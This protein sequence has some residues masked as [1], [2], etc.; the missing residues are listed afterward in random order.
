MNLLLMNLSHYWKR[1]ILILSQLLFMCM[2][3]PMF[4][5]SQKSNFWLCSLCVMALIG[6][7]VYGYQME[8]LIKPFSFTLPGHRHIF[9][10]LI[11][12]VIAFW[13]LIVAILI[14]LFWPQNL[15]HRVYGC[16]LTM[17]G[18]SLAFW[19]GTL[20]TDKTRQPQAM[21]GMMMPVIVFVPM[22]VDSAIVEKVLFN[23]L[24]IAIIAVLGGIVTFR[25][26]RSLGQ[27]SLFA[28]YC[29]LQ[30]V[31]MFSGSNQNNL[32]KLR[33]QQFAISLGSGAE[34]FLSGVETFFLKRIEHTRHQGIASFVYGAIYQALGP[35]LNCQL[36]SKGWSVLWIFL[37]FLLS[38]YYGQMG[39][40]IIWLIS[41][42]PLFWAD[43]QIHSTLLLNRGRA[44]RYIV[45]ISWLVFTTI[46]TLGIVFVFLGLTRIAEPYM[47]AIHLRSLDAVFH[48]PD[49]RM[50]Y[51]FLAGAPS[52]ALLRLLFWGKTSMYIASL[53][54]IIN[55]SIGFSLIVTKEHLKQINGYLIA[56]VAI[57]AWALFAAYLYRVCFKKSLAV[58]K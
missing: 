53:M 22:I 36:R 34:D 19:L 15:L 57:A 4:V 38:G 21:I 50:W 30:S 44:Q 10:R 45:A 32:Q 37:L 27:L 6:G 31:G 49:W 47:P 52:I 5:A 13:L 11:F 58:L 35:T 1:P 54:L 24:V 46:T 48:A 56:L 29:G 42:V 25:M 40:C 18:G 23:P 3:L 39:D 2:T 43:F 14:L 12:T 33:R 41:L 7:I 17:A 26:W 9:R 55:F 8:I 28:S 51:F 20:F 16:I